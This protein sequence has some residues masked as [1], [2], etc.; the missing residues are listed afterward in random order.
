MRISDWSSDVCSSDL[1]VSA[2]R[3]KGLAVPLGLVAV[4]EIVARTGLVPAYLLP[5]PSEV[6]TEMALLVEGG[7]L[8]EHIAV[9]VWRVAIGFAVGAAAA[10]VLGA[11]TGSSRL[12]RELLD[13]TFQALQAV[14][15]LAWVPLSSEEPTSELQSLMRISYA[16]FCL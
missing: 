13:P 2:A 6:F 1:V 11:L 15:S 7:E 9:T 8:W 10:T 5:G 3:L 4:W 14:P 16:V 12:L